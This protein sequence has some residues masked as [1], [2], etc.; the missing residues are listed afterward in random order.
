MSGAAPN[1][2]PEFDDVATGASGNVSVRSCPSPTAAHNASAQPANPNRIAPT[3]TTFRTA[4]SD[5]LGPS[6]SILIERA[7]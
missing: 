7:S 4:L 5:R 3:P 6:L 1:R 2:A